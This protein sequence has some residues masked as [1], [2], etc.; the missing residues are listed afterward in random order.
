[1]RKD[2]GAKPLTYPQPVYMIGTY[3]EQDVQDV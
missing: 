3:D 2:F 1:M